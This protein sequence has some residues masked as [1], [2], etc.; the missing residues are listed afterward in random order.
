MAEAAI[1]EMEV[2]ATHPFHQTGRECLASTRALNVFCRSRLSLKR[3]VSH[4]VVHIGSDCVNLLRSSS[5]TAKAAAKVIPGA[6][7]AAKKLA[8]AD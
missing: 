7:C 8:S 1:W 5:S 2:A 6:E 3:N 4:S